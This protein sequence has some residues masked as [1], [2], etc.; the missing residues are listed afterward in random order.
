MIDQKKK[1]T[2]W[3]LQS[4]KLSHDCC[5]GGWWSGSSTLSFNKYDSHQLKL[6]CLVLI[7]AGWLRL[8]VDEIGRNFVQQVEEKFS[9]D[10]DIILVCQKGLRWY[11]NLLL[12]LD[13]SFMWSSQNTFFQ[14]AFISA[15]TLSSWPFREYCLGVSVFLDQCIKS[16]TVSPYIY[17]FNLNCLWWQFSISIDKF[18][19]TIFWVNKSL[20]ASFFFYGCFNFLFSSK[21]WADH[22]PP[23]NSC[24][25][26]V[27]KIYSGYKEALK[28]PKRRSYLAKRNH[29]LIPWFVACLFFSI[30]W[31][32]LP[33]S[34]RILRGKVP[35]L[36]SLPLL[37]GFLNSLGKVP[38]PELCQLFVFWPNAVLKLFL[39]E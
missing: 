11:L 26:L 6:N 39:S 7:L 36:S 31:I 8:I 21:M 5:I 22:L 12:K 15:S 3:R 14:F 1:I 30:S 4:T 32:C 27:L 37:E 35:S 19:L 20:C 25:M 38:W 10:T 17:I 2:C 33:F 29:L 23:V 16:S 28:L 24:T 34:F 18:I 9:K 13:S